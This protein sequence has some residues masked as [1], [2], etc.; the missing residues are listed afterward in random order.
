M[1][2]KL[3]ELQRKLQMRAIRDEIRRIDEDEKLAWAIIRQATPRKQQLE[4][5]LF[6]LEK[7]VE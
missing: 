3:R 6:K 7:V 1:L 5:A 4:V 2:K